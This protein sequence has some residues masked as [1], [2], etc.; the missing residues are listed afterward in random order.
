[1]KP[2][3]NAVLL[4]RV[5]ELA[6]FEAR[7]AALDARCAALDFKLQ[8]AQWASRQRRVQEAEMK[9]RALRQSRLAEG[10]AVALFG[11]ATALFNAAQSSRPRLGLPEL[12]G[13]R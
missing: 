5:A 7:L 2:L 10:V 12:P 13:R 8:K 11:G 1:M 4:A 6:E 3:T 9:R